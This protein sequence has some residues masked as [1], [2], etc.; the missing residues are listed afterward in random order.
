M[1]ISHHQHPRRNLL[2]ITGETYKHKLELP[3]P[4][5]QGV[6]TWNVHFLPAPPNCPRKEVG[7]L[8]YETLTWLVPKRAEGPRQGHWPA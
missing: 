7:A 8:S 3:E 6:P 1:A 2:S 4:E 5:S